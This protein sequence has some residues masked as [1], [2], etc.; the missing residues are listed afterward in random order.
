MKQ[1]MDGYYEVVEAPAPTLVRVALSVLGALE[2]PAAQ[3][4]LIERARC[5][6]TPPMEEM[7]LYD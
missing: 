5:L 6:G 7:S 1:L 2:R 4:P 3:A